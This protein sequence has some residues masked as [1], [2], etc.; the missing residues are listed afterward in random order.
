MES[1]IKKH[2]KNNGFTLI[3][4]LIV[5]AIIGILAG[6]ILVA[7]NNARQ[8][9]RDAAALSAAESIA[10][11][12]IACINTETLPNTSYVHCYTPSGGTSCSFFCTPPATTGDC[13]AIDNSTP[14]CPGMPTALFPSSL[15][16]GWTYSSGAFSTNTL[17]WGVLNGKPLMRFIITDNTGKHIEC[18]TIDLSFNEKNFSCTIL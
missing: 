9:A 3:E 13:N 12:V 10:K 14:I 2:W 18:A 4:L 8:K 7:L 11:A 5:I 15:P 1:K 16:T 17:M 6:A